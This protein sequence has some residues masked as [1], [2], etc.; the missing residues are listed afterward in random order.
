LRYLPRLHEWRPVR[1]L[2]R[3][4]TDEAG[5]TTVEYAVMLA[6]I[7]GMCIATILLCSD[8]MSGLWNDSAD[9]LGKVLSD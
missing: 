2:R 7:V 3:L 1:F 8:Q 4:W 9:E 5:P 6:M